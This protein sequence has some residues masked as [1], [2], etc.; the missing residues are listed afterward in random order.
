MPYGLTNAPAIFQGMINEVLR[1]FLDISVIVYLDD[2]L[3]YSDTR[4]QHIKDVRNVL[5]KLREHRLWAKLEKCS[6]FQGHCGVLRLY[7]LTSWSGD[8]PQ[9]G[10]SN[11]GLA[12][13]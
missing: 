3:I 4:E 5:E 12:R 1:M 8:G 11:L 2:I 6:F 13:T 10:L 9:E 7:S